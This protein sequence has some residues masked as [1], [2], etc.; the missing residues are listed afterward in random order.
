MSEAQDLS[1]KILA[2]TGLMLAVMLQAIDSTIANVAL[3]HMQGELSASQ[4]Q[5]VWV[6]T[7]YILAAAVMTPFTGW[8]AQKVGRKKVYM[9]SIAAFVSAS[10]MCSLSDTLPEIVF[11]RILQGL[12]GAGMMPLSQ[13]A[14]LDIW[15]VRRMATM[16]SIW[17][18]TA[19]VGPI[20]GPALGGFLTEQISWRW[21]FFINV[22]VGV[23]AFFLISTAM[24]PDRGG[25]QRPFDGL[26]FAALVLFSASFQLMADRGPTM[27]WF[28]SPEVWTE[29]LL[30]VSGLY[31]FIIRMLTAREPFF[32]RDV[33]SNPNLLSSVILSFA[34]A[35]ILYSTNAMMPSF[36][37]NLMGYSAQQSGLVTMARGLGALLGFLVVPW[38]ARRIQPRPTILL[39]LAVSF[40]GLWRMAHFDLSMTAPTIRFAIFFQGIGMAFMS[41][42]AAVLGY[43]TLDPR[44]RT[45]AAVFSNVFRTLGGSLGIASMQGM[46]VVASATAHEQLASAIAPT[47]PVVRWSL[48]SI[49]NGAGPLEALNAEVTRQA[50][51]IGYD[52]IFAKLALASLF[53]APLLLILRPAPPTP[54]RVAQP[55]PEAE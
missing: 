19:M 44:H 27:D 4:D 51:M 35:V 47:D 25:R 10:V 43:S 6:L 39:G 24:A 34:L 9:V 42:P 55:A 13:A 12:S 8:I 45:E 26:G 29:A 48:P 31:V 22:P 33:L 23:T 28:H 3:P 52:I 32:H 54:P 41:N 20:I 11:F 36:M 53:L 2:T 37:Q 38:L 1:Q 40:F 7:S 15:S 49:F 46:F 17:S 18:A 30:G 14:L 21:V 50:A 5:I 16:M